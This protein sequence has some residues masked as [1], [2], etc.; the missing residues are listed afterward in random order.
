MN[1]VEWPHGQSP[2]GRFDGLASD[3]SVELESVN[4]RPLDAL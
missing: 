2:H 1:G 3:A 4:G